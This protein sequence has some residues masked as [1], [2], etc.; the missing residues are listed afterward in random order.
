MMMMVVVVVMTMRRRRGKHLR[1]RERDRLL[2]R[3]ARRDAG[4]AR[5]PYEE[6]VLQV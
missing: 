2:L 6:R 5:L 3:S 1:E 4:H